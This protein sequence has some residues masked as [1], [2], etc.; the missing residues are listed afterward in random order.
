MLFVIR[1]RILVR[2]ATVLFVLFFILFVL[3]SFEHEYERSCNGITCSVR[4]RIFCSVAVRTKLL[5]CDVTFNV[6]FCRYV[7]AEV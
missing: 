2:E 5:N 1:A 3:F 4:M 7:I 6:F